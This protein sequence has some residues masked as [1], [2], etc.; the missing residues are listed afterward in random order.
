[1]N[2]SGALKLS[3]IVILLVLCLTSVV[4]GLQAASE[5]SS[6]IRPVGALTVLTDEISV[7]DCG[8]STST[9]TV[10]SASTI[11]L[12]QSIKDTASVTGVGG[13]FPPTGTVTFSVSIDGGAKWTQYGTAVSIDAAGL[14]TSESYTPYEA[15]PHL[16][17]AAYSG[18]TIYL[19]SESGKC[20]E[21]LMVKVA[22]T[23]THTVLGTTVIVLGQSVT[24]NVTIK[25]LGWGYPNPTG[26]I[27]FQFSYNG[28]SWFT[29]DSVALPVNGMAKSKMYQPA[30]AGSYEFRAYYSGD[31]NYDCSSSPL[32]EEP[33]NVL[34]AATTTTT[35]LSKDSIALGGS[36]TDKATVTGVLGLPLPTGTVTFWVKEPGKT[37]FVQYGTVKTLVGGIA[38]SDLYTPKN[39]GTY[40]F[41]AVYSGD[42]NY[43]CSA[44]GDTE[45]P[46]IVNHTCVHHHSDGCGGHDLR[47]HGC[48]HN[49]FK[50]NHGTGAEIKQHHCKDVHANSGHKQ[51]GAASFR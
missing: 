22:S 19:A 5:G 27:E 2:K 28:A 24:D 47:N 3:A 14:A 50:Y 36:V 8:I 30:L 12:G 37:V 45:E 32:G 46:L 15:G 48:G 41:K 39:V 21:P 6:S 7:T 51:C 44:S 4:I 10:L 31:V 1:M 23:G 34:K 11:T 17:K 33:L 16:F 25:G 40:Q 13:L 9:K 42:S 49:H 38:T 43:K 18:D 26:T 35:M 20:D 29:Y